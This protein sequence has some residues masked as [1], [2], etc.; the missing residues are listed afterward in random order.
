MGKHMR[1]KKKKV[2]R[3]VAAAAVLC[4][5]AVLL[6]WWLNGRGQTGG[7]LPE[8]IRT[9]QPF[10][11]VELGQGLQIVEMKDYAGIYMEDG[12][13]EVVSRV[14]MVILRNDSAQDLQLARVYV[15]GGE[16]TYVFEATN[17]P[18]GQSVVLLEKNRERCPENGWDSIKADDVVFFDQPM[19]AEDPRLEVTGEKGT[20]H[21]TNVSETNLTGP[22]YVYYKNSAA[23]ILYGG[24]TYRAGL[25]DGLAKGET[26]SI[27]TGHYDPNTCRILHVVC[28]G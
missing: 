6:V 23:D 9:E 10:D 24:I 19:T 18:A 4:F 22:I 20:I 16:K 26:G 1:A 15:T 21:I 12:S 14:M 3:Y 28:E 5:A 2:G 17:L 11:T 13:D 7:Q 27:M 8:D 25:T